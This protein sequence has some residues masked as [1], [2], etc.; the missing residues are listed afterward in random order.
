MA[1]A[2]IAEQSVRVLQGPPD[3]AITEQSARVL[4]STPMTTV[5]EQSLQVLTGEPPNRI[6]EQSVRVLEIDESLVPAPGMWVLHP[7]RGWLR[8]DNV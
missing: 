8:L 6:A 5:E 7:S 4:E 2:N 3:A 1:A